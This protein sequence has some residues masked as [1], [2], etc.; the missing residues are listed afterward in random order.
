MGRAIIALTQANSHTHDSVTYEQEED[1]TIYYD[2]F[3]D[4]LDLNRNSD[5]VKLSGI[6]MLKPNI[7]FEIKNLN[8]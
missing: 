2:G 6:F 1:M 3:A 7:L 5:F 8:C 4:R